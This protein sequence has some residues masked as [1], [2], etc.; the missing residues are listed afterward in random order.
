MAQLLCVVVPA[1]L[2]EFF[3]EIGQPVAAGKFLP[4]PAMNPESIENIQAI[5]QKH[6][7][8]VY[9]PNFLDQK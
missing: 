1:G 3:E 7:Q 4:P 8:I 9:P 2:E 5:A 6:G